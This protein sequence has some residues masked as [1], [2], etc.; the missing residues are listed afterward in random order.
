MFLSYASS[1]SPVATEDA[2]GVR[3]V[4]QGRVL[5]QPVEW[6]ALA[7]SFTLQ[8]LPAAARELDPDLAGRSPPRA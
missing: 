3:K 5:E 1:T 8:A 4:E 6:D 2:A 7:S